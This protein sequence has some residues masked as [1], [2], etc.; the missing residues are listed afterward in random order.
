MRLAVILKPGESGFVVAECPELPGCYSQGR[1]R[2]EALAN[3]TEAIELSLESRRE[4]GLPLP[5]GE[6]RSA[7][8]LLTVEV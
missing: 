5:T 2:D 6:Q 1:D 8:E 4:L 3:I 7:V